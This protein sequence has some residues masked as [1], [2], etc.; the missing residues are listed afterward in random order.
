VD[1]YALTKDQRAF[2]FSREIPP[3]LEV[4]P[5][6]AMGD[7]HAAMGA[8]EPTWVSLEAP[9]QATL[10]IGLEKGMAITAPR[11]RVD[12]TTICLGLGETFEQAHQAALDH[13]FDLLLAKDLDPFD[14]YALASARLSMRLG[15]P[16]SPVVLAVV[17]DW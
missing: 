14:D 5:G 17:P 8:A 7:L 11:L 6:A 12:G 13:A 2:S 3:V 16:V 1:S 15:G 10:R 4:E 9:G